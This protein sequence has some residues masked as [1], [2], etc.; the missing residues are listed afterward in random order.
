MRAEAKKRAAS[1]VPV[2][3]RVNELNAILKNRYPEKKK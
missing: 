2:R 3:K 1:A